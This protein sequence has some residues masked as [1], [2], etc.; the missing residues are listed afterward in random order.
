[1]SPFQ[2]PPPAPDG[3][4]ASLH[5]AAAPVLVAVAPVVLPF[6]I[7]RGLSMGAPLDTPI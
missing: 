5:S 4:V 3:D 7:A 2:P 6:S 1:M